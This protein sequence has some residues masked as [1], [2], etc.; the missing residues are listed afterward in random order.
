MKAISVLVPGGKVSIEKLRRIGNC[1]VDVGDRVFSPAYDSVFE[2]TGRAGKYPPTAWFELSRQTAPIPGSTLK[3]EYRLLPLCV[4][5]DGSPVYRGDT[6]YASDDR[7]FSL[8]AKSTCVSDGVLY[9]DGDGGEIAGI[10]TEAATLTN[11]QEKR[12]I[13]VNVYAWIGRPSGN[14]LVGEEIFNSEQDALENQG[15]HSGFQGTFKFQ[16]ERKRDAG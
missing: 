9:I 5:P 7:V 11:P 15:R 2:I 16:I 4:L 14:T 8:V 3:N 12:I 13:W 10:S 6:V 1:L